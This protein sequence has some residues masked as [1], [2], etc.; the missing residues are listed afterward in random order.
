MHKP[1]F[2]EYLS[3]PLQFSHAFDKCLVGNA[4]VVRS[5]SVL[6]F[7]GFHAP[8]TTKKALGIS[9]GGEYPPVNLRD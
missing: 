7:G 4:Q 2:P 9:N 8:S 3:L 5:E 6:L 1:N